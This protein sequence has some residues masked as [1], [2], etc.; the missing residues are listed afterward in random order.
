M[1]ST[2]NSAFEL[3]GTVQEVG[4]VGLEWTNA[5][6]ASHTLALGNAVTFRNR[7]P[8]AP[9]SITF[10]SQSQSSF[11][12]N[13]S[14]FVPDRDGFGVFSYQTIPALGTAW[15]FGSYTAVA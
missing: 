2:T 10:T 1:N 15:W 7:F 12:G 5:D 9:S 13:P 4:R 3:T 14:A 11:T 6:T 8:A